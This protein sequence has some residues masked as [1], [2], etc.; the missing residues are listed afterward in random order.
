MTNSPDSS[1]NDMAEVLQQCTVS[2]HWEVRD[3]AMEVVLEMAQLS[4]DSKSTFDCLVLALCLQHLH[5]FLS[6]IP[7]ISTF[8]DKIALN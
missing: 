6:R 8:A 7:T 2:V 1:L 5:I 4:H 3:S